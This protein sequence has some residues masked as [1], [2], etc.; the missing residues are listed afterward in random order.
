M[1]LFLAL[2]IGVIQVGL[3]LWTQFGIQY[4]S[5]AAA[6]CAA[7]DAASCGTSDQITA[8]AASHALGLSLPTSA[9]TFSSPG[10]GNQVSASYVY[11]FNTL[12]LGTPSVTLS[13]RS[14]F[15]VGGS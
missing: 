12:F 10:C 3:A 8:Y 11:S 7:V 1:P 5:E 9:F 4:G 15:P 2:L 13:A 6:R 14:C